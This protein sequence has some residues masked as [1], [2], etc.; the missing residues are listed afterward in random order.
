MDPRCQS[1]GYKYPTLSS[2][3]RAPRVP[4]GKP[5]QNE[6]R[7]QNK[8]KEKPPKQV[9]KVSNP[10]QFIYMCFGRVKPRF[11]WLEIPLN[12]EYTCCPN[13]KLKE[14]EGDKGRTM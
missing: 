10:S 1:F 11:Q 3:F 13:L 2:Q 5:C 8:I 9:P 14:E 6:E 4:L 12:L 7:T